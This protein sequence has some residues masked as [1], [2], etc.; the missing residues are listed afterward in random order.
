MTI[1]E[2]AEIVGMNEGAAKVALHRARKTL[3]E[4]FSKE[5]RL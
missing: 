1:R 3:R 4:W 2:A 5:E